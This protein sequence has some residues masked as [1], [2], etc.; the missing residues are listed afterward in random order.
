MKASIENEGLEVSMLREIGLLQDLNH[1][2]II[3]IQEVIDENEI[4]Y[5]V[6]EL[7]DGDLEKFIKK[8]YKEKRNVDPVHIKNI[9]Y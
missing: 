6:F 4:I 1:K 7:L 3:K 2:N 5:I 9:M 8:H